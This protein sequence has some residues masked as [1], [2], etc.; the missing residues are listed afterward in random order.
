MQG[1]PMRYERMYPLIWLYAGVLALAAVLFSSPQEILTGLRTIVL[2]EDALITD[3]VLI[4]GPG[5]ALMN[6]ALVTAITAVLLKH[7][8]EPFNGFSVVVVGLMSGFS[9]FGKNFVNIWPILL[10]SWLYAKYRKEPY[11]SFVNI[12][13]MSTAL[14]P[15][16]SYIALDNGWGTPLSGSLIGLV[17]GFILP[18]LATYTYRIQN[19]MNLYNV[20]FACGLV[21]FICVPLMSS[22]GADP[23]TQ[24]RWA[25]GCNGI[26]LP[27]LVILC[28]ILAAVCVARRPPPCTSALRPGM[29]AKVASRA[30]SCA[31]SSTTAPPTFTIVSFCFIRIYI[32]GS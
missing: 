21:A 11:A 23:T 10:G 28:L 5:A 26:F 16:I 29:A 31:A 20:G 13:L 27:M 14:A 19:G 15:V 32:F 22:L 9:L 1:E 4:A 24:Y 3:Y 30:S 25:H 8:G 7:S 6:S 17:I 2:T 18:P 12:G